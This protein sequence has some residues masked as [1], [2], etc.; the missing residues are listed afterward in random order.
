MLGVVPLLSRG[1]KATSR[2]PWSATRD[3]DRL[4]ETYKSIRTG[5]D[6]LRR[7]WEGKVFMV[8]SPQPADGKSRP[9]VTWRSPWPTPAKAADRCRPHPSQHAIH[10]LPRSPGLTEVL[11]DRVPF[12]KA[13]ANR[14]A[15]ENLHLLAAGAEVSYPAELLATDRWGHS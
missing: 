5:I 2:S 15:V 9:P 1:N 11:D 10:G 6:L 4:A 14:L 12:H 7:N 13:V 3:R 8:T